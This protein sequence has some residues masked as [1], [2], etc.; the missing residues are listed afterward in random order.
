MLNPADE[1]GGPFDL[2]DPRLHGCAVAGCLGPLAA[3]IVLILAYI[4]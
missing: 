2:N 1:G 3:V 4:F